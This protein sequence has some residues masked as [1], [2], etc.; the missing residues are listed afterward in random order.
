MRFAIILLAGCAITYEPDVGPLQATQPDA[1]TSSFDSGFV[2]TGP[3]TD[4]NPGAMV[5]FSLHVRPLTTRSPGGCVFCHGATATSGFSLGSY[6]SLRRG[7]QNSGTRVIVAGKPCESV[8]L[9]KLGLA[10]P[11]GARMPYNG[12]PYFTSA[13]LTLVRDWIAEGA[14]N[15]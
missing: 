7:G 4:S 8:L 3:C 1:G 11:F 14:L 6:D 9:Q 12:P 10:P 5:S 2:S 15:N 13:E